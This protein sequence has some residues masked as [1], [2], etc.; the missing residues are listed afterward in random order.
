MKTKNLKDNSKEQIIKNYNKIIGFVLKNMNLLHKSDELFD[1]GMVGFVRG[2]NTYDETKNIKYSTYLYEC[3]KN[4]ILRYL[5]HEKNNKTISLN[6]I[7]GEDTELLDMIPSYELYDE[8]L[9]LDEILYVINRRLSFLNERDEI[10]FKHLYGLDGYKK[11]ETI[12]IAK[13]FGTS[14]QNI[15]RIKEKVIR[16]LRHDLFTSYYKS[17]QEML[18]GKNKCIL[19]LFKLICKSLVKSIL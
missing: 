5:E 18:L 12:E 17:Y 19:C 16:I 10:V 11:L 14:K 15:Q 8:N 4:E 13:K 6:T 3:I 7:I 1:V 9:Y 2:I